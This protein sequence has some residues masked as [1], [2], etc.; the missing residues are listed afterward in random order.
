MPNSELM[1]GDVALP[2]TGRLCDV[3]R[4]PSPEC[5]RDPHFTAPFW[6]AT[7]KRTVRTDAQVLVGSL[8]LDR[9]GVI[10]AKWNEGLAPAGGATV[11]AVLTAVAMPNGPGLT[12][13]PPGRTLQVGEQTRHCWCPSHVPAWT[14]AIHAV[15]VTGRACTCSS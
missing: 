15:L 11:L 3:V 1:L 9:L 4:A 5:L 13:N 10:H 6:Q 14:P 7:I 2:G 12:E 8:G